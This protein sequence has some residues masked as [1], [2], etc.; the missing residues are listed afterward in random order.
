VDAAD[1]VGD[2]HHRTLVAHFGGDAEIFDATL[3]QLA[4]FGRI[5]LHD[6]DS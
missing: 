1:T 3:D 6:L 2:G 4:D 5:E